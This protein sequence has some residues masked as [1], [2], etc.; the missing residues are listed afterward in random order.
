[1]NK[2]D[3]NSDEFEDFLRSIKQWSYD[4]LLELDKTNN[5]K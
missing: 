5:N 3:V 1:M 4:T 2:V